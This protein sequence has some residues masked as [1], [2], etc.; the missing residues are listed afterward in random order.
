MRNTVSSWARG[1]TVALWVVATAHAQSPS[2]K[3]RSADLR[4]PVI[5]IY[6][7]E[8]CS[9]CPPA[10]AWASGLKDSVRRGELVVQAFHV[11]YWDYI[12]WADRFAAKEHTTRQAWINGQN[13]LRGVYTPQVLLSGVDY[14]RWPR[15]T[16]AQLRV[17]AAPQGLS[18]VRIEI[19]QGPRKEIVARITPEN[20]HARWSAYWT[21]TEDG[22]T[23]KVTAGENKGEQLA[24]DFVVRHYQDLGTHTDAQTL[25]LGT[26]Y[27]GALLPRRVNVVVQQA[28]TAQVMQSLIVMCRG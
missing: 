2:C 10:D 13:R 11:N 24:H 23:S 20:R 15:A 8:G 1:L 26:L 12:G 14:R 6:T 9:S 5:E 7:S 18:P 28:G 16:P 22:H 17:D 27:A 19:E 21:L 25:P 4:T 3:A